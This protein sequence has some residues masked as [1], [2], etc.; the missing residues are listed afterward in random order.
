MSQPSPLATPEPWN[1]VA[2]AYVAETEPLFSMFARD[3]LELAQPPAGGRLVDVAAGGGVLTLQA[4][5]DGFQVAAIDFSSAM[6]DNLKRRAAERGLSNLDVRLGDGQALPFE[7]DAFD[8]GFSMFGL[9]FFPDRGAGLRELRRVLRPG[10][11]AV[12]SAWAPLTGAFA[13]LFESI[14]LVLPSIPSGKGKGPLSDPAEMAQEMRDAGF[15]DVVVHEKVHVVRADSLESFWAG[16]QRTNAPVVLLQRNMGAERWQEVAA[17]IF[18][19]LREKLGEG[20][21]EIVGKANL[22]VGTK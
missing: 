20:P 9:M 5:A 7:E 17:G 15:A 10:S 4:V 22:G 2:D 16:A 14:Q 3:A 12:I 6:L 1:L 19:R 13:A 21:V 18:E 11:R 8:A